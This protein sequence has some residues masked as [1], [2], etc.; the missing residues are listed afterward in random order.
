M[1]AHPFEIAP[2]ASA[3]TPDELMVTWG[4]TPTLSV[5]TI[6]LP[7]VAASEIINLAD[8]LYVTHRLTAVDPNTIQFPAGDVTLV[9]I[10]AGAGRDA[11]LLSVALA[12]QAN[13][14]DVYR[15]AVR[16]LSQMSSTVPLPPP[17]PQVAAAPARAASGSPRAPRGDPG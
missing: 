12:P 15:I 7:A 10:P 4:S 11:G 5:G 9:P 3:E 17:Q 6:Y 16:Q 1:I 2:S 13:V 8:K 14:G